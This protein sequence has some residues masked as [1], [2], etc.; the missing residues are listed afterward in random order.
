MVVEQGQLV[1]FLHDPVRVALHQDFGDGHVLLHLDQRNLGLVH[2]RVMPENHVALRPDNGFAAVELA[3]P[4][5]ETLP[6]VGVHA[7]PEIYEQAVHGH[8]LEH[9][10][11]LGEDLPEGVY[12]GSSAGLGRVQGFFRLFHDQPGLF[13]RSL[14]ELCALQVL[15]VADVADAGRNADVLAQRG[16]TRRDLGQFGAQIFRQ[17]AHLGA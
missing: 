17:F 14:L 11:A 4:D 6:F 16:E 1:A 7:A 2:G 10:P 15:G 9:H 8:D 3:G 12:L 5:Q 13:F